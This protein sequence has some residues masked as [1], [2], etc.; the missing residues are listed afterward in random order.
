MR[1]NMSLSE[2]YRKVT[3]KI[4]EYK[5]RFRKDSDI[6]QL[7][8]VTK[9]VPPEIVNEAIELG[10]NLLGENRVQEFLLKKDS[11]KPAN[12]H[13]IGSLQ[14]NKVRKI[15]GLVD[16]I[17]SVDTASLANEIN[18]LSAALNTTKD[19]LIELNIG[20]EDS[21][22]GVLQKD[23]FPLAD[24]VSSLEFLKLRGIMVI[25]PP[26][27]PDY[28][29]AKTKDFFDKAKEKYSSFDTLSMGMSNDYP[30]AIKHGSN[31]IRVGSA[32][33]GARI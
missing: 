14:S 9:T 21:K 26:G 5:E 16:M 19:V 15:V 29:F 23:F 22:S 10:I 12:V 8:A 7:M 25:P 11:Y 18:R 2:N 13:F 20:E 17:H 32:L 28:Y 30:E 31:I 6:L 24:L 33:F 3:Q 1:N 27:N 4:A